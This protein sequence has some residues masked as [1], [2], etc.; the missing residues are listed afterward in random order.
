MINFDVNMLN[1]AIETIESEKGIS[2]ETVLQALKDSMMRG[3]RKQLGFDDAIVNAEI[4]LDKGTIDLYQIKKVVSDVQDDFLEI[5]KEEA[6]E[7]DPSRTYEIGD[8]FHIPASE[9]EIKKSTALTIKA[10]MKQKFSEA[11]KS[12]LLET[13][14]D[15]IGTMITGK[16]E[17]VDESGASVNIGRTSVFLPR[18]QIIPGE[19]LQAGDNI[20]LFVSDVSMSNKGARIN[21]SRTN[22]G[23]LKALFFEEIHE[24]YDGTII[25]KAIARQAGERSKIAVYS[26]D[27]NVDPAGACIGPNGAR[28]Q[29]IV[30][31]LGNGANKEKIDIIGYSDNLALFAMDALK[32]ANVVGINL[33]SDGKSAIAI[34]KDDGLSVAIGRGG[35]NV[36]LASKLTGVHID[37]KTESVANEENIEFKTFEEIQAEDIKKHAEEVK[38]VQDN[39]EDILP[40]MPEGYIAPQER[41][42]E[43]EANDFDESLLEQSEKEDID[44]ANNERK[45]TSLESTTS[46]NEPSKEE[47]KEDINENSENV[48]LPEKEDKKEV[49]TTTTLEDLE[50]TLAYEANKNHA[51]GKNRSYKKNKKDDSSGEEEKAENSVYQQDKSKY[52]SIYTQEELDEMDKEDDEYSSYDDDDEDIDYD[53]YDEYYDDDNK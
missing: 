39:K 38:N 25:I 26:N 37:I 32:P 33:A 30:S 13:F 9:N 19:K 11:E 16:I 31:Q 10:V 46:I 47:N 12:S 14:K 43:E 1:N 7:L 52:M 49:E 18:K 17:K 8:E 34:V 53:Q 20:K 27:P 29:K 35:V 45:E 50:K 36:K 44:V 28:I 6:E 15:K 2:K 48:T 23:F 22:E 41:V 51:K 4:D 21:V 42:Y 5:S 3:Y 40:S 24:I